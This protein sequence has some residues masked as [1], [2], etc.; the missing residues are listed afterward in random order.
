MLLKIH[1]A[2][3]LSVMVQMLSLSHGRE[4]AVASWLHAQEESGKEQRVKGIV[5][6]L[7][8]FHQ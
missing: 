8:L 3:F 4:T 6:A 1:T 2:V 7:V 5:E